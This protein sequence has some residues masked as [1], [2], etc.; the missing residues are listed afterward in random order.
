MF[1]EIEPWTQRLD[2]ASGEAR[3]AVAVHW[4][5][6]WL[7][8]T[9]DYNEH[10][11]RM[12]TDFLITNMAAIR[13][14]ALELPLG[15]AAP[16][17]PT[18]TKATLWLAEYF[19]GVPAVRMTT[20]QSATELP[21]GMLLV[22]DLW[23]KPALSDRIAA[24][25]SLSEDV[26]LL[27]RMAPYRLKLMR[28]AAWDVAAEAGLPN[29]VAMAATKVTCATKRSA[30]DLSFDTS[31]RFPHALALIMRVLAPTWPRTEATVEVENAVK[32]LQEHPPV[33]AQMLLS[34]ASNKEVA[35][36]NIPA[37]A[38]EVLHAER[39]ELFKSLLKWLPGCSD[40]VSFA[41]SL[42]FS[43]ESVLEQIVEGF[44]VDPPALPSDL[45]AGLPI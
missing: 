17:L 10:P 6:S 18:D 44:L 42:D 37:A 22:R 33:C 31:H 24:L 38:P 7:E 45:V 32:L 15:Y 25:V 39:E 23:L 34:V 26:A 35:S 12:T 29:G 16:L 43:Y 9:R 14:L 1:F 11:S 41:W 40:A 36:R 20:H 30:Q 2:A 4:L 21:G 28:L 19:T 27:R 8:D 3:Q 5:Q 13:D